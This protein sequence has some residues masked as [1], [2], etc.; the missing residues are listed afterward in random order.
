MG[1]TIRI[2]FQPLDNGG[3]V[4]GAVLTWNN[5][6]GK[7]DQNVVLPLQTFD[8]GATYVDYNVDESLYQTLVEN[9]LIGGNTPVAVMGGTG[10][11]GDGAYCGVV[12]TQ[13]ELI[14]AN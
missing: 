13:V 6:K 3:K 5:E 7:N 1:S 12:I 11:D 2:S 10:S 14:P 8:A 9:G 4:S